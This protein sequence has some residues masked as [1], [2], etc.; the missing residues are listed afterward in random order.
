MF[1]NQL[2][3]ADLGIALRSTIFPPNLILRI[4]PRLDS[5][6]STVWFPSVEPVFDSLEMCALSL[7]A[8]DRLKAGTG[9][10]RL[11]EYDPADLGR[12][13]QTLSQGSQN[14]FILG[15]GTGGL[16]GPG[17]VDQ[18]VGL[19]K[20]LRSDHLKTQSIPVYF[21][22]LGPRM[23]RAGFENAEGVILNFCSPRYVSSVTSRAGRK[24]DDFRVT[25]YIK[26]FFAEDDGEARKMLADEFTHYHAIPQYHQMFEAMGLSR[27]L[28][29]F[30]DRRE[31]AARD[32]TES[33][34]EISIPNPTHEQVL[35]LLESFREAGVDSPIVYP[36]VAGADDFK[37]RV[38][39]KLRDWSK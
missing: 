10:I 36:Y 5:S 4:S 28:Q 16:R 21:A 8:T 13:A 11:H 30:R 19:T 22:A 24:K 37:L 26:L 1:G 23:V 39:E 3:K 25:C 2:V 35:E 32:I 34:S 31:I 38:V 9:V 20:K 12:R 17:A 7:G 27:T 18:L 29:V 15:V 6:F 14:R 33:I